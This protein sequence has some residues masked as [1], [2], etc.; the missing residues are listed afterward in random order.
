MAAGATIATERRIGVLGVSGGRVSPEAAGLL[1]AARLVVGGRRQLELLAPAGTDQVPIAGGLEPAL[2]ALGSS[3]DPAC[4]LASGD[5]GFF[6][7]VRVLER[8]FGRHCL[9]IHPAPSSVALAFARLGLPWD[10]AMV[11]S[12]H[13]RG[14]E[15]ALHMAMRF[16]KVAILTDPA[17]PPAW[18]ARRLRSS[19]SRRLA[20]A[21]RL[22]EPGERLVE[23]PAEEIAELAAAEPNVLLVWTEGEDGGG[24]SQAWPPR[25]PAAGWA[26]PESR[27]E[28]RDGMITKVDVRALALA[29]LGPRAGDLVWDVGSGSGSVGIECA[30]LGA[31]VIAL[32]TDPA[33]VA[34]TARNAAAHGVPV[35]VVEGG[36]PA[37]LAG[38]PIPDAVF[39]GGGGADLPA[40]L[41]LC[42]ERARRS[43]VASLAVLDRVPAAIAAFESSGWDCDASMVHGSSLR[44]I[45]GGLRL[46]P[47]NP[48]FVLSGRRRAASANSEERNSP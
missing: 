29:R 16:P 47:Q 8:R 28:H 46:A 14:P 3:T 22:G 17:S 2:D 21:E 32:D 24:R 30:L 27:F 23:A 6:G 39:V 33:A 5:P 42:C 31:A 41:G 1:S 40:I 26:L 10:D 45:P 43:V 13:A 19:S 20:V 11:V 15:V 48:V 9:A 25:A 44:P 37:A 18:F 35:E 38:L 7:I 12:A 36:A 34:T 4:V